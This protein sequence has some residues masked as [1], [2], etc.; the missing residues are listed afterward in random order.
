MNEEILFVFVLQHRCIHRLNSFLRYC[1]EY[2]LENQFDFLGENYYEK[3][4]ENCYSK[5]SNVNHNI[6]NER[7]KSYP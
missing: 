7:W 3:D 6:F 4:I 5:Y 2:N 1:D